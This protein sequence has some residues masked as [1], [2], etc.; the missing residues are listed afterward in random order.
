LLILLHADPSS[1][2]TNQPLYNIKKIIRLE[3]GSEYL[4]G[5]NRKGKNIEITES[6]KENV[7]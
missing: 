3:G 2:H 4:D 5:K 6:G 1:I 7:Q